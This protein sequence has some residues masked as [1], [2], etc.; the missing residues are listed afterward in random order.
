M[1]YSTDFMGRF[2]LSKRLTSAQVAYLTQFSDTR[3]IKRKADITALRP[4]PLREAVGLPVGDEGGYFVG[5]LGVAGQE[6]EPHAGRFAHESSPVGLDV[7]D[8][9]TPPTGQ[10]GLWC[11][12]TTTEDGTGIMWNGTEKFYRYE[13]WLQYLITH[14][15]TPWGIEVSGSVEWQGESRD[16]RGVIYVK[17]GKVEKV[18]D[19]IIKGKRG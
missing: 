19:T 2:N 6:I 9:N 7:V 18:P 1:G 10:P 13:E 12:W 17:G 8:F 11:N 4:D 14:F 15:L 16:D 3:R 5:A